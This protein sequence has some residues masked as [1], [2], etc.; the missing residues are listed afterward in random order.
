MATQQSIPQ[1]I[2]QQ[3]SAVV[4][5]IPKLVPKQITQ[6]ELEEIILLRR[7]AETLEGLEAEL[8]Q[9]LA[10]GAVV[11]DGIHIARLKP[12]SRR[13]V[14]WR[15]VAQRLGDRLFGSGKGEPYC[16]KVL[17]STKPTPTVSLIVQ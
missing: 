11:E 15:E 17:N 9:R 6:A 12:G 13:N 4:F 5:P 1:L 2:E 14:A 8:K 3:K 10:A 7:K 16:D